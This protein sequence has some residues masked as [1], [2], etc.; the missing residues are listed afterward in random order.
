MQPHD[1]VADQHRVQRYVDNELTWRELLEFSSHLKACESC[2]ERVE[3]ELALSA[4]LRKARP[5]YRAPESL[6]QR[7]VQILCPTGNFL[8]RSVTAGRRFV[9]R[10]K[11]Q[12]RKVLRT[13]ADTIRRLEH[14]STHAG[15][16]P[17]CGYLHRV[18][19]WLR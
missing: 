10:G 14:S 18:W 3:E 9:H 13:V 16:E 12:L 11:R 7:A 19:R 4:I 6:H 2:R 8:T 1:G 15:G 5:L 17:G